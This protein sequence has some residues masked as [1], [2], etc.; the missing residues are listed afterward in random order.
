MVLAVVLVPAAAPPL[1]PPPPPPPLVAPEPP[2]GDVDPAA[3]T[4]SRLPDVGERVG[5][6][7]TNKSDMWWKMAWRGRTPGRQ[8]SMR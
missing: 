3:A 2:P 1:P 4:L 8:D 7:G 6:R 5:V